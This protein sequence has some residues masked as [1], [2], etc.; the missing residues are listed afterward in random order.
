[1]KEYYEKP[2]FPQYIEN[3]TKL[4]LMIQLHDIEKIVGW[5]GDVYYMHKHKKF[6]SNRRQGNW[7]VHNLPS[8]V[9]NAN[10]NINPN[11]KG[12]RIPHAISLISPW[13]EIPY[14]Q[15]N[16]PPSPLLFA[17]FSGIAHYKNGF[18]LIQT[19]IA[20]VKQLQSLN[21]GTLNL[22]LII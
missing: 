6:H 11:P 18:D 9:I 13:L 2:A 10:H 16:Q 3:A 5:G 15:C 1:M 19:F 17:F 14:P 20:N 8:F 21:Q 7:T 22:D 4:N 12:V